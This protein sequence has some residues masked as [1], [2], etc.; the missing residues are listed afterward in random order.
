MERGIFKH[1]ILKGLIE[2][3]IF[4]LNWNKKESN[5]SLETIINLNDR[6]VYILNQNLF[7]DKKLYTC[8]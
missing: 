1:K 6:E 2:F 4:C 8:S 3:S 7:D 5:I